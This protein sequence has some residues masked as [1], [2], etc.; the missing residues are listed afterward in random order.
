[1]FHAIVFKLLPAT[2]D[3][4]QSE[5]IVLPGQHTAGGAW[6]A[7]RAALRNNSEFIGGEIQPV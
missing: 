5:A 2:Q 4:D 6:R 7:V 1:M 3:F